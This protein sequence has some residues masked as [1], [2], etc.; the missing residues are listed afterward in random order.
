MFLHWR[1]SK[2]SWSPSVFTSFLRATLISPITCVLPPE[3]KKHFTR[4]NTNILIMHAKQKH[5]VDFHFRVLWFRDQAK[6]SWPLIYATVGR[7]MKPLDSVVSIV[8]LELHERETVCRIGWQA[9]LSSHPQPL[10]DLLHRGKNGNKHPDWKLFSHITSRLWGL[11]EI[12]WQHKIVLPAD[13]AIGHSA[14]QPFP[15][16]FILL[17]ITGEA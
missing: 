17:L 9:L 6:C 16:P 11:W 13:G 7:T 4:T 5:V 1:T 2:T 14:K 3:M 12:G 15:A 10:V 8:T